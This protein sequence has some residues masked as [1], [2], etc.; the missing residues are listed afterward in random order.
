MEPKIYLVQPAQRAVSY[1]VDA[2]LTLVIGLMIPED[3]HV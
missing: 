3:G 1:A 2:F